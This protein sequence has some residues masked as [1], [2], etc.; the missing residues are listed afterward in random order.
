MYV[1]AVAALA[2]EKFHLAGKYL[3]NFPVFVASTFRFALGATTTIQAHLQFKTINIFLLC[4]W[5]H[6]VQFR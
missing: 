3:S 6:N 4:E 2:A 5:L 1:A